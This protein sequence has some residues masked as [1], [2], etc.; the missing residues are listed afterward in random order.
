MAKF[1]GSTA[2]GWRPPSTRTCPLELEQGPQSLSRAQSARFG[3]WPAV[4]GRWAYGRC[5]SACGI[6]ARRLIGARFCR[7]RFGKGQMPLDPRP[8]IIL[9]ANTNS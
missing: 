7:F 9:R 3:I 6:G 1:A 4:S 5:A 8:S 2:V